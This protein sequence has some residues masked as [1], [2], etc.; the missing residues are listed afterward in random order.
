MPGGASAKVLV[1]VRNEDVT[2]W[3]DGI[4]RWDPDIEAV[5]LIDDRLPDD[6]D[7]AEIDISVCWRMPHGLHA[8]LPN[9]KLIQ[10]MAAG[11]DH[12]LGDPHRP[13]EVPVARLVD[14][15]MARSMTHHVVGQILRWHR[16]LD[17]FDVCKTEET[18]PKNVIFDPD[19]TSIGIL[20]MGVLGQAAA[21]ALVALGFPVKGWSRSAKSV[22]GIE[23]LNGS[24]GLDEISR[25]S[26][27]LVCLLPLTPETADILNAELFA[28][29]PSGGFLLNVGRGGHLV[30][31]DLLEALESGRLDA[32]SLDVFRTEPLPQGHPFWRHPKIWP[33]P[34]IASE[35]NLPTATRAFAE[36]IR[37]VRAGEAPDGLIDPNKGY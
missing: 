35:I 25:S 6:L 28:K 3:I 15:W 27:A 1:H 16:T 32:A 31:A 7:P 12:I 19:A 11:V 34:H 10:S 30:E 2:S 17:R 36:T 29:M 4:K 9:L 18:W 21:R 8:Q 23:V 33:T 13:V 37:R 24:D 20:G 22:E 14:P 5:Q 26:K